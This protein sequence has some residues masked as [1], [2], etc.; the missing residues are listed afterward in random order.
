MMSSRAMAYLDLQMGQCTKESLVKANLTAKALINISL[1]SMMTLS[2]IMAHGML[3]NLMGSEEHCIIMAMFMKVSL[4]EARDQGMALTG[5]TK[6]INTRANGN[7]IV[8]GVKASFSRM[9]KYFSKAF[10]KKG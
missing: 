9:N 4:F 2:N 3:P 8:F 6:S 1:L 10:L 5:L 7:I